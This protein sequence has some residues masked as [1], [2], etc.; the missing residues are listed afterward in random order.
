MPFGY[1]SRF[2]LSD[3]VH[4][5]TPD[6][7]ARTLEEQ[8]K[9][10]AKAQQ[11]EDALDVLTTLSHDY[12]DKVVLASPRRYVSLREYCHARRVELPLE[13]R[14][15]YRQRVDAQAEAAYRDGLAGRDVA[16]LQAVVDEFFA[17][18]WGDDALWTLGELSLEQGCYGAA[19]LAWQALLPTAAR[20]GAATEAADLASTRLVY[21]DSEFPA[22]EVNARLVLVSVLEGSTSRA[23]RELADFQRLHPAAEGQLGGRRVKLGPVLASQVEASRQWQQPAADD[24]W[25]TFAGSNQRAKRLPKSVDVGAK[26]WEITLPEVVADD[27]PYA[28][29]QIT[30]WRRY[31][32]GPL[33]KKSPLLLSHHPVV[34]GNLMFLNTRD[35]VRAYDVRT[36]RPAWGQTSPTVFRDS[37]EGLSPRAPQRGGF[38]VPR[39]TLTVAGQYLLA[40]MGSPVT[41]SV[42]QGGLGDKPGYLVCLDLAAQGRLHWKIAP[43]RDEKWSFEGTPVADDEC[44]Y[45]AQ[46]RGGEARP[47]ALVAAYELASGRRRWVREIA[48]ADTL[49]PGQVDETTSNLLT[50]HEG[51]LYFNSNLGAIAAIAAADGQVRWIHVYRQPQTGD[52]N[53]PLAHFHRD[54]T[55]CIYQQG[56]VFVAPSDT[57]R[58][59]ALD[60]ATG[61]LQWETRYAPDA[62][63]LLGVGGGH[64]LASG[65]RIY[66]IN[67][68][69]G[70]LVR[71]WPDGPEPKGYGR[72]VLADDVVYWP[73]RD[74]VYVFSQQTAELLRKIDL[75]QR[76][77]HGTG[78]NL[79]V[80][81]ERLLVAA[82]DR[83]LAFGQFSHVPRPG[84]AAAATPSQP[85]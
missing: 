35:E 63:H 8:F 19:R 10:Y 71:Y 16:K 80:T 5:D 44:V 27:P 38:G 75:R 15:L 82:A 65:D 57:E 34:V 59:L 4:L 17:S 23:E 84:G 9:E 39:Y 79:L 85:R 55:P 61:E 83:L 33:A 62:L 42:N 1:T 51:V 56:R 68:E 28:Y 58:I 73:T 11:W 31:G 81:H 50:L 18:S 26:D 32:D 60:A 37:D 78:G 48:G 49:A 43:E 20:V 29:P 74:G 2:E 36:G 41:S 21:P 45:V 53:Q 76:D 6:H 22:A 52:L 72:G 24:N 66:W 77:E 64:L 46:R 70:K 30:P 7:K 14:A 40:R 12:G 54:L 3:S 25:P 67:V 13:V 69:S 47:H